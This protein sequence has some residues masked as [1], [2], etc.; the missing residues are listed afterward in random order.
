MKQPNYQ[1]K[2]KEQISKLKHVEET[3]YIT[4]HASTQET[5]ATRG[6]T[7]NTSSISSRPRHICLKHQFHK[8]TDD[9][10]SENEMSVD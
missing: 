5:N 10:G 9:S 2:M 4:L 3:S 1:R 6:P 7:S 8:F